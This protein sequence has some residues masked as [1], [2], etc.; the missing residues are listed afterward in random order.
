MKVFVPY[1]HGFLMG[2]YV[3]EEI[4]LLGRNKRQQ[5][6]LAQRTVPY[7]NDGLFLRR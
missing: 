2:K 5:D 1:L 7:T 6:N 4:F 3:Y